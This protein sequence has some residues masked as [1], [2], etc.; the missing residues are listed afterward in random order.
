[1]QI[2]PCK[3]RTKISPYKN[4]LKL[5]ML[6]A[7][8]RPSRSADLANLDLNHRTYSVEEVTFLP[9]AL[10]KQSRNMER[11]STSQATPRMGWCAQWQNWG[12]MTHGLSL[13]E[14]PALP[15][16]LPPSKPYKPVC[17]STIARWLKSL[18][19]KAGIDI[20]TFKA[21]LV[22]SASTSA[23]PAAG[24]TTSDVL[25]AAD[26]SSEAVFQKFY[27]K[28]TRNNQFGMAVLRS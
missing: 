2:N 18:M 9:S 24:A 17:S 19:G 26:W 22:R 1:M 4:Y 23:A 14:A 25:K 27:H 13:L 28:P 20:G 21:Y 6:I 8:T 16:S 7:L 3:G 5:A 12:I 10:S 11:S 15:F